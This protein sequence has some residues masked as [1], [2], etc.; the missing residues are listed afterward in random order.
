VST[1]IWIEFSKVGFHYWPG[2][3]GKRD[4][5]ASRHRHTFWIKVTVEVAHDDREVEFHDLRDKA[6]SWWPSAGELGGQSCE[7]IAKAILGEL[8]IAYGGR[9]ITVDVSEDREAGAT[10]SRA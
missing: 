9:Q 4:Y 8:Q 2:A 1:T 6:E 7:A 3:S 5:L 10:V